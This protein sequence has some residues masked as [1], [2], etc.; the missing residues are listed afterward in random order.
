M[1]INKWQNE[2]WQNIDKDEIKESL[3]ELSNEELLDFNFFYVTQLK[4]EKF[5]LDPF[6]DINLAKPVIDLLTSK[7]GSKTFCVIN[8][9]QD[10]GLVS[11]AFF[12]LEDDRRF[13]AYWHFKDLE[14]FISKKEYRKDEYEECEIYNFSILNSWNKHLDAVRSERYINDLLMQIK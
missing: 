11:E 6:V 1:K 7:Y 12:R 4:K 8:N 9:F 5:I 2:K 3:N 10:C 14:K 13:L